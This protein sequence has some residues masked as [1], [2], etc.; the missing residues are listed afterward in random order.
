[1]GRAAMP[2]EIADGIFFLA[3]DDRERLRHR[4]HPPRQRRH[5]HAVRNPTGPD[6]HTATLVTQNVADF[7]PFTVVTGVSI[8][9]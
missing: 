3:G 2:E 1:M 6:G 9:G 5:G 4:R 7:A 8:G